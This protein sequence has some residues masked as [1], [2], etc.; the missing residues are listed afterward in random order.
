MPWAVGGCRVQDGLGG[1]S[2]DD[3]CFFTMRTGFEG[4][5]ARLMLF[6]FLRPLSSS[7]LVVGVLGGGVEG[8]GA[9]AAA[10]HTEEKCEGV[11]RKMHAL[12]EP[13]PVANVL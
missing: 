3:W 7:F 9:R 5:R 11:G 10:S 2:N 12:P 13:A 1:G 8:E 6:W 4:R